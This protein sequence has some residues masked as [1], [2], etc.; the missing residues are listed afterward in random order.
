MLTSYRQTTQGTLESGNRIRAYDSDMATDNTRAR[1]LTEALKVFR[2]YVP[3]APATLLQ[4][5]LYIH[6][7][8]GCRS[9][10]LGAHL[11]YTPPSTSRIVARLSSRESVYRSGLGWVD[12]D[13][14][15]ARTHSLSLTSSGQVVAARVLEAMR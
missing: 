14:V 12:I 3:D 15:D 9:L 7:N 10:D 1:Q 5:L 6:L 4:A 8:P 11:G 2:G 13:N